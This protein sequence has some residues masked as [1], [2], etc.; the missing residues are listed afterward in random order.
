MKF[1]AIGELMDWA[2][3]DFLLT[4]DASRIDLAR[5]QQLLRDTYWGLRRPPHVVAR[6]LEHSLPFVL[7][8][9][10][11]QI[12]FGRVVT[13]Y[14]VFSWVADI[15]IDSP[16]RGRGLGTWMMTC[17]AEHP[18]IRGTQMVL[19]TRD[20]HSLYEK[21]GFE[22]NPALMSTKVDGL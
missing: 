22:E 19:Q 12:G 13:D 17:I 4:D 7:L 1:P 18:L 15:V 10:E 21:F 11:A 5:T 16:F 14:T 3:G 2:L 6:M 9:D 20:A 8:H